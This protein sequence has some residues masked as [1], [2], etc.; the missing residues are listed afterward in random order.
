MS[1]KEERKMK[2]NDTTF[3]AD[4]DADFDFADMSIL[5]VEEAVNLPEI[6]ASHSNWLCCSS[7]S[8][9]SCC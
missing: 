1:H 9:S 6:G 2:S 4:I 3:F 7:S 8:S 5:S